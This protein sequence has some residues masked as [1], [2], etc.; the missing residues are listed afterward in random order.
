MYN[1]VH[2]VIEIQL[3]RRHAVVALIIIVGK[4]VIGILVYY[5][6]KMFIAYVG[7]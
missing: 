3:K 6:A 7:H 2:F 1:I 5:T 4:Y